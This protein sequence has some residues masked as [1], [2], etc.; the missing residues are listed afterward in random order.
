ML[1]IGPFSQ[2]LTLSGLP[3]KGPLKDDDLEII[4]DG[5]VVTEQGKIVAVTKFKELRKLYVNTVLHE[6]EKPSVLLPGFVDS[7]THICFAG[8]RNMDYALRNAGSSYLEI[9][10]KG[11][12]IRSTVQATRQ[13]SE[14]E[15]LQSLLERIN[16][17]TSEGVTTIEIKSGYGLNL[18]SELKMLRVIKKARAFTT[19]R[20]VS[21]CLAAHILPNDFNGN[22]D[23]YLK[24]ISHE[25]LPVLKSEQLTNRV[26]IFIEQ[27]A[28]SKQ[29]AITFLQQASKSG[30]QTT[31]HADQ[32]TAGSSRVAVECGAVSAD[33]LEAS[34]DKEIR[35]LAGSET[36]ATVLPGASLGLGMSFAPA[37]KL[38]DAGCCVAIASD[39]NPGS[40]P[41]GDLL[42]QA[43][44]TG[45]YEKLS[46]AEVFAGLTYRA[47]Q[48]LRLQNIGKVEAGFEAD[49]QTYLTNDYRDILYYQGKMK[50]E[51]TSYRE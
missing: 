37:R 42:M 4:T 36:V 15:L 39:W 34:T 19:A 35:A 29:S 6:I 32:F 3:L 5:G 23:E 17:H 20:L 30:F 12:G 7:H 13:A 2:I 8:S 46:A 51:I 9:A 14:D 33:H 43:A 25:L 18:E 28:F 26:D 40:A 10:T 38:L 24:W 1:L 11:G 44:I 49:L 50:P 41:Q 16:R 45:A 21:T 47:A 22:E 31:V 27:T 48:A